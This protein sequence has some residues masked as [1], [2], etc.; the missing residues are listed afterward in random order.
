[1]SPQYT[2]V[3]QYDKLP[4]GHFREDNSGFGVQRYLH[5]IPY[6]YLDDKVFDSTLISL[7]SSQA[8]T[9]LR[10]ASWQSELFAYLRQ[11]QL[12][13]PVY[14]AWCQSR[15]SSPYQ[16]RCGPCGQS[17]TTYTRT[18]RIEV[19]GGA[20]TLI[21]SR[22]VPKEILDRKPASDTEEIR[23]Y[24]YRPIHIDPYIDMRPFLTVETIEQ[25]F[26]ECIAPV[27]RRMRDLFE[28][29]IPA[30]NGRGL[31]KVL[32][33]MVYEYVWAPGQYWFHSAVLL[34]AEG[35]S[36]HNNRGIAVPPTLI[37]RR[38][39][40][41]YGIIGTPHAYPYL[42]L[43]SP[44]S[45]KSCHNNSGINEWWHIHNGGV[46]PILASDLFAHSVASQCSVPI[47]PITH[48]IMVH[49]CLESIQ[50]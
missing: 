12:K 48:A 50:A 43:S 32:R 4:C 24:R 26:R 21:N 22:L 38:L 2:C 40:N 35:T 45:S 44:I 14:M 6:I 18:R 41:E 1:M 16:L 42:P 13:H 17:Q 23:N 46:L 31:P 28:V 10:Y 8:P 47:N 30:I 25:R 9:S 11:W 20:F 37:V 34:P 49:Y 39:P 3:R 19:L 29:I 15:L 27:A 5:D 36:T 7:S 33:K